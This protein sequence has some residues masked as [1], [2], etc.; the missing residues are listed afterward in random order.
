MINMK[1]MLFTGVVAVGACAAWVAGT[2]ITQA[3]EPGVIEFTAAEISRILSH[4]PWPMDWKPD[5]TNRVSGS[6]HAIDLGERALTWLPVLIAG[7]KP[8]P[9]L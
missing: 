1:K 9:S 2:G 3:N 4:G 7:K 6:T 8:S 5:A